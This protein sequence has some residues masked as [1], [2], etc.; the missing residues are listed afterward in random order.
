MIYSLRQARSVC[1]TVR[2]K[3]RVHT[4]RRWPTL[5]LVSSHLYRG[6]VRSAVGWLVRQQTQNQYFRCPRSSGRDRNSLPG[7]ATL[8]PCLFDFVSRIASYFYCTSTVMSPVTSSSLSSALAMRGHRATVMAVDFSHQA[9]FSLPDLTLQST[10]G[11]LHL[12]TIMSQQ[13][14]NRFLGL[15]MAARSYSLLE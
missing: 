13:R 14:K 3:P 8:L 11:L 6:S 4:H 12:A 2:P 1:S 7:S 9:G 10:Q 5:R 15:Q